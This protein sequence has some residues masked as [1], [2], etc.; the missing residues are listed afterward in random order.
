MPAG[1]EKRATRENGPWKVIRLYRLDPHDLAASKLRRFSAKDRADVRLLCDLG[2]LN[3][4][5][6]EQILEKAFLWNMDKDGDE[7]RDSAFRSLRTV[8]QYLRNE[9]REF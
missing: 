8:Q 7:F 4:E 2:C 1:F 5:R 6:L 9:I 3:P